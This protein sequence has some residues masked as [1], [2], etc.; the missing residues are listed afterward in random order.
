MRK[1]I[2]ATVINNEYYNLKKAVEDNIIIYLSVKT[3][4]T[5]EIKNLKKDSYIILCS[6]KEGFIYKILGDHYCDNDIPD[7][8]YWTSPSKLNEAYDDSNFKKAEF[9]VKVLL[10]DI[11]IHPSQ[12]KSEVSDISKERIREILGLN[13]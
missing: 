3:I 8:D 5:K 11:D 13:I 9:V 6:G 10:S 7:R 1:N 4:R 2:I 12:A